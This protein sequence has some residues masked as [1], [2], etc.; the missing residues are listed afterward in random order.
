MAV[1]KR[2]E[3]RFEAEGKEAGRERKGLAVVNREQDEE[4]DEEADKRGGERP[5]RGGGKRSRK[6]GGTAGREGRVTEE[7]S[8]RKGHESR[9]SD[10]GRRD[11]TVWPP[12][13][14]GWG[15]G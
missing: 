13:R 8:K 14:W 3:G 4:Q 11:R 2:R 9:D 1:V 10:V 5:C 7:D 6:G 12:S 15:M